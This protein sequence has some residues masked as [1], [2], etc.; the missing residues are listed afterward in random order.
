MVRFVFLIG[1]LAIAS[2]AA[3][4][5]TFPNTLLGKMQCVTG[6]MEQVAY[7]YECVDLWQQNQQ[8]ILTNVNKLFTCLPLS[9]FRL[10]A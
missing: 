2:T 3:A 6:T 5:T 8:N 4:A 7:E 1:F 10:Q 9:G